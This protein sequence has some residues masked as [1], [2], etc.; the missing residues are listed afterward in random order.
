[1][2]GTAMQELQWFKKNRDK[3]IISVNKTYFSHYQPTYYINLCATQIQPQWYSYSL[4]TSKC[5][6]CILTLA[7]LF[8]SSQ[9]DAGTVSVVCNVKVAGESIFSPVKFNSRFQIFR[10]SDWLNID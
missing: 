10:Q 9:Y 6:T 1:M 2:K 8:G 3:M 5:S 7:K 4:L